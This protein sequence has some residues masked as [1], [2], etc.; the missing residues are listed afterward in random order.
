MLIIM[1][2]CLF[3]CVTTLCGVTIEHSL[4]IQKV[5]GSNLGRSASRWRPWA[6]CSHACAFVT[7]QYNLVPADGRWRL[8]P[9]GWLKVTCG[10]TAYTPGSAPGPTLGNE[11]GGTLLYLFYTMSYSADAAVMITGGEFAWDATDEVPTVTE[12]VLYN[13]IYVMFLPCN[14]SIC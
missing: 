4:V 13:L 1:L 7:K 14:N 2:A 11:Y 8:P 10:L 12:Y 3:M 6:S 9:G 5:A